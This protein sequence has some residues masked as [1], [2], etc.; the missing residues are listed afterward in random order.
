[1]KRRPINWMEKRAKSTQRNQRLWER[2]LNS[3]KFAHFSSSFFFIFYLHVVQFLLSR[4]YIKEDHCQSLFGTQFNHFLKPGE[5]QIFA[6]VGSN[7]VSIYEC[8]DSGEIILQQCYADPDV[9]TCKFV[10]RNAIDLFELVHF[11]FFFGRHLKI[12][13]R[14]VGH[15]NQ[16]MVYRFWPLPVFVVSFES[17]TQ[18]CSHPTNTT[19]AMDMPSTNL[20][21]IQR[22]RTY[23]CRQAK[24]THCDCGI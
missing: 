21:S 5:P 3:G 18:H 12:F 20:N 4:S 23:C 2:H 17:L 7:R 16:T 24:T 6:T 1:M 8:T 15:V 13:T 22:N 9:S 11:L 14:A 10:T 19:L